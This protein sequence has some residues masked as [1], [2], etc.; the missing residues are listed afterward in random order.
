MRVRRNKRKFIINK[1]RGRS[2]KCLIKEIKKNNK[3]INIKILFNNLNIE[4][5]EYVNYKIWS[6]K[7]K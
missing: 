2:Q 5:K 3:N 4:L 7:E 1:K 6:S